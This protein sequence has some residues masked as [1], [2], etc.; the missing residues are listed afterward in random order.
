MR[1]TQAE[2]LSAVRGADSGYAKNGVFRGSGTQFSTNA[3]NNICMPPSVGYSDTYSGSPSARDQYQDNDPSAL[4]EAHLTTAAS[5]RIVEA[6]DYRYMAKKYRKH[7]PA[8]PGI[9]QRFIAW[10]NFFSMKSKTIGLPT[11]PDY[12]PDDPRRLQAYGSF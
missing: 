2:P 4:S 12:S 7:A 6:V 9:W 10:N 5:H 3:V 1:L 8:R 11:A